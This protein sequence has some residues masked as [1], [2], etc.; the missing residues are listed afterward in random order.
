MGEIV[1]KVPG[2]VERKHD[3]ESKTDERL[4]LKKLVEKTFGVLAEDEK[5]DRKLEEEWY[6]Q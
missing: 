5:L 4:R 1:I 3:E 6:E 2:D